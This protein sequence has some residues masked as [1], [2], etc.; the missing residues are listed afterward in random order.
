MQKQNK[1]QE[2]KQFWCLFYSK[3]PFH[4]CCWFQMN[5]ES[6]Y[7]NF[8]M[9]T[10]FLL[11]ELI[12]LWFNCLWILIGKSVFLSTI[13]YY[14]L[15]NYSWHHFYQKK[16]KN[17][18]W[19]HLYQLAYICFPRPPKYNISLYSINL[20]QLSCLILILILTLL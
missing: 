4:F 19:H 18:S 5:C 20:I 10:H 17:Y 8:L 1:K 2:A 14:N 3:M 9:F 6:F 7:F 16:K 15:T 12:S 13:R 11:H